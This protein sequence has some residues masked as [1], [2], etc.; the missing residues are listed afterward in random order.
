MK[1]C[2]DWISVK[3]ELPVNQYSQEMTVCD[4]C[5]NIFDAYYDED[6]KTWNVPSGHRAEHITHWAYKIQLLPPIK[7][8]KKK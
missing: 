6:T 8:K 5:D 1:I 7:R 3:K 2:P 4:E